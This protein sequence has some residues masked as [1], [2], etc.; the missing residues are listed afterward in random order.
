MKRKNR[1]FQAKQVSIFPVLMVVKT[2]DETGQTTC[3]PLPVEQQ[4]QLT[5]LWLKLFWLGWL[6]NLSKQLWDDLKHMG[7][8][9]IGHSWAVRASMEIRIALILGHQLGL[10]AVGR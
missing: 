2:D 4:W 7:N 8:Q 1:C 9:V 10:A 3:H 6:S 5:L